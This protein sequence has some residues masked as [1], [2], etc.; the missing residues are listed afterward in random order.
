MSE[1][2]PTAADL[3]DMLQS[4]A[5]EADK[6]LATGET[7]DALTWIKYFINDRLAASPPRD[8]GRLA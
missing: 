2:K 3:L 5:D 6:G 4:I 8:D 1:P 7:R